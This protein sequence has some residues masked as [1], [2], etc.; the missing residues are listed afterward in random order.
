MKVRTREMRQT[1]QLAWF[2]AMREEICEY[3]EGAVLSRWDWMLML[4]VCRSK[5]KGFCGFE[6][7][8]VEQAGC[9]IS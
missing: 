9:A 1:R 7:R 8:E 4:G 5:S 2:E 3:Q 6:S